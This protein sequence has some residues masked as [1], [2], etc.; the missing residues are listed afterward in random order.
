MTMHRLVSTTLCGE[1]R[2]LCC[3]SE[4]FG[5][6]PLRGVHALRR[7]RQSPDTTRAIQTSN[8]LSID[9][10]RN[11]LQERARSHPQSTMVMP[12]AGS[13]ISSSGSSMKL[14]ERR[15]QLSR[16]QIQSI[17][18]SSAIPMVGFGVGGDFSQVL[19]RFLTLLTFKVI[20]AHQF[21]GHSHT[22]DFIR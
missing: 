18:L 3:A 12:R 4:G 20:A 16:Q 5:L 22:Y 19:R 1:G 8:T 21:F 9:Q 6:F 11:S 7:P 14:L 2:L 13:S 10:G 15:T 17:V